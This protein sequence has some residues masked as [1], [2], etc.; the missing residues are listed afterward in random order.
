MESG[1]FTLFGMNWAEIG[2]AVLALHTILKA[3]ARVTETKKDDAFVEQLG[4]VIG[5]LFGRDP[6]KKA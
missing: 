6:K 2:V 3:V 1:G 5:Y 4:S